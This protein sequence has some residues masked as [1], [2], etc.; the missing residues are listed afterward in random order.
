[1]VPTPRLAVFLLFPVTEET[2]KRA[3]EEDEALS[4]EME[5]K[6]AA[7]LAHE[8]VPEGE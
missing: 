1:M 3:R 5:A 6:Q 4:K 2:D 8:G 7:G